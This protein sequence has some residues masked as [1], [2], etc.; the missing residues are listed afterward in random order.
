MQVQTARQGEA[1][2][3]VETDDAGV[4]AEL[5]FLLLQIKVEALTAHRDT[6]ASSNHASPSSDQNDTKSNDE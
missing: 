3:E 5:E 6:G 4:Q 1:F 2:D